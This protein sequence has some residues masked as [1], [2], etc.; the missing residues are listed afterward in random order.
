MRMNFP[1]GQDVPEMCDRCNIDDSGRSGLLHQVLEQEGQQE[2]TQVV[3]AEAQLEAL[4][5][6]RSTPI[7]HCCEKV[8]LFR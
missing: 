3:H 6:L 7:K 2:V 1:I 4:L 8:K 5:G